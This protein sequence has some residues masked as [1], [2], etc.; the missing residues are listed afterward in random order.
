MS[1]CIFPFTAAA[2]RRL[3]TA[4]LLLLAVACCWGASQ[5]RAQSMEGGITAAQIDAT[6]AL[7]PAQVRT[8][9]R[10]RLAV[11]EVQRQYKANA[12]DY[13]DVIRAFYDA[14]ATLLQQAGW[15]PGGFDALA[16]RIWAAESAMAMQEEPASPVS[17]DT[18]VRTMD[19]ALQE[20]LDQ[21]DA[22][23][24]LS[25]E[26]RDRM[27]QQVLAQQERVRDPALTDSL[28]AQQDRYTGAEQRMIDATRPDWPAVRS[29][30][31]TLAHLTEYIADNRPDPPNLDV[32]PG[33]Q[34]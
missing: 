17:P 31:S 13:D 33:V 2:S 14:R 3:H 16:E 10:L 12:S 30:R 27:R 18:L 25:G 26:E 11:D 34:P 28:A 5:A 15:T 6:E 21:I 29:Y 24:G 9:I 4:T 19:D 1:V 8:F 23:P 7:S 32:R 22:M 20:V